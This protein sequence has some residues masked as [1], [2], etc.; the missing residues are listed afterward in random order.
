MNELILHHYDASSY[1]QKIRSILGYKG[2]DWHSVVQPDVMPKAGL[3]PLTGGY[4]L[5][6]VLQ[7]GADVFCDSSAIARRLEKL[8]PQPPIFSASGAAAAHALSLWGESIF[9]SLV[10]I[11]LA[12]GV[13]TPPS[14][15]FSESFIADRQKM[16]GPGFNPEAAKRFIDWRLTQLRTHLTILDRHLADGR[17]Y[18]LGDGCGIADFSA[19]HPLWSLA[20]QGTDDE[21]LPFTHASTWLERIR[22]FGQGKRSVLDA[23]SALSLAA[24]GAPSEVPATMPRHLVGMTIGEPVKVR[25]EAYDGGAVTGRLAW[26]GEHDFAINLRNEQVGEMRVY[27]PKQGF[28]VSRTQP[29][30]AREVDGGN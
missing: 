28:A 30:P 9:L 1:S 27:F 12:K 11:G 26:V 5:L 3:T 29:V 23:R 19:Y 16:S 22:G 8:Y 14:D 21:L 17:P 10:T 2:L 20:L 13:F 18:L 24:A 7:I 6:P 25:H 15:V 4:R